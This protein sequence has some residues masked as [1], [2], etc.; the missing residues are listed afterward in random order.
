MNRSGEDAVRG[1]LTGVAFDSFVCAQHGRVVN[2]VKVSCRRTVH[3]NMKE[4]LREANSAR[5]TKRG[6]EG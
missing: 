6:E 4:L 1:G 5:V 3:G 2:G